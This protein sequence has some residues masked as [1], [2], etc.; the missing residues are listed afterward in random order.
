MRYYF[1]DNQPNPYTRLMISGIVL[2]A[3]AFVLGGYNYSRGLPFSSNPF[4]TDA[5]NIIDTKSEQDDVERIF[6]PIRKTYPPDPF[7]GGMK[8]ESAPSTQQSVSGHGVS[9]PQSVRKIPTTPA[10]SSGSPA[11]SVSKA[12]PETR[13]SAR[14]KTPPVSLKSVAARVDHASPRENKVAEQKAE[15]KSKAAS[16]QAKAISEF[17]GV[18][19]ETVRK[20]GIKPATVTPKVS[21]A[22]SKPSTPVATQPSLEQ[23]VKAGRKKA[24]VNDV[25][26]IKSKPV[27][28]V[29]LP[30]QDRGHAGK[31]GVSADTAK[32]KAAKPKRNPLVVKQPRYRKLET[33]V[34]IS[35][36][37]ETVNGTRWKDVSNSVE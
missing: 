24:H 11:S 12:A 26:V 8:G 3:L 27:S 37:G 14:R 23:R 22:R 19:E 20:A 21:K 9:R 1:R 2:V 33:T 4:S 18:P 25:A 32:T 5:G 16:E 34:E 31:R 28:R 15:D 6:I 30:V 17:A 10:V 13:T 7:P 35:D 36:S 29:V